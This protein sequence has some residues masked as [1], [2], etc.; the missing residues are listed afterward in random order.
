MNYGPAYASSRSFGDHLVKEQKLAEVENT[1]H[2]HHLNQ[3]HERSL[4]HRLPFSASSHLPL[5]QDAVMY[6]P[7]KRTVVLGL[8]SRMNEPKIAFTVKPVIE[9]VIRVGTPVAG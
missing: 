3:E 9:T 8:V 6:L 7:A 1:D 4:Q 5:P 2:D